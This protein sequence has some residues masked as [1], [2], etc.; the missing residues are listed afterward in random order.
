MHGIAR[1]ACKAHGG[2]VPFQ[3]NKAKNTVL[4][5]KQL[6]VLDLLRKA[7]QRTSCFCCGSSCGCSGVDL[8][9][10]I[11]I[12]YIDIIDI[13]IYIIFI[14]IYIYIYI[15][16]FYQSTV[17]P[18][19]CF[20]RA[21]FYQSTVLLEHCFTRALFYQSIVLPEHCYTRALFYQSTVLPEH[22]FTRALFY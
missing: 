17:L 21:L 9:Y 13:Y 12:I 16:M 11:D 1:K 22:C 3:A 14:H 7:E 5:L 19:H 15:Y 20:T 8:S 10:Y 4:A 18:E 6:T 2:Y